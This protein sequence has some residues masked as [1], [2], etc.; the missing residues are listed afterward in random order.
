MPKAK[1]ELKAALQA[2]CVICKHKEVLTEQQIAKAQDLGCA[3]CSKCGNP[4]VVE[5]ITMK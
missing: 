5:R 4:S 2:K 1:K 3:I